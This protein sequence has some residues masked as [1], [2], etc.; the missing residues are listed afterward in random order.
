MKKKFSTLQQLT[1]TEQS[2]IRGG[3]WCGDYDGPVEVTCEE[4][5]ALPPQY[6]MCVDVAADC[7]EL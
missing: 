3:G 5:H 2:N 4:F 1:K 6:Q 7:F